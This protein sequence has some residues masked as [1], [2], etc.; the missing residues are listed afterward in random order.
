MEMNY[1]LPPIYIRLLLQVSFYYLAISLGE[2]YWLTLLK[3]FH[4]EVLMQVQDL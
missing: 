1:L 4:E 3:K 2:V